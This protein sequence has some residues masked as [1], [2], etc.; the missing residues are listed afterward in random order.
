MLTNKVACGD[1][2]HAAVQEHND[3]SPQRWYRAQRRAT[4]MYVCMHMWQ[5]LFQGL[6]SL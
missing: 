1:G 2:E 6:V 5:C 4:S 3:L